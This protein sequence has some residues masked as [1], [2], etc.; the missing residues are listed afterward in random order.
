MVRCPSC[1]AHVEERA[2]FCDQCGAPLDGASGSGRPG[3]HR[4]AIALRL[5]SV[6]LVLVAIVLVVLLSGGPDEE[7]PA[8]RGGAVD[9]VASGDA[10]GDGARDADGGGTRAREDGAFVAN[11]SETAPMDERRLVQLARS[12]VVVLDLRGEDG[13]PLREERG[14]LS[15]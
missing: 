5:A 9:S 15:W 4:A 14:V 12:V 1:N 8:A 3:A 10:G 7:A 2:V 6:V 13:R 11:D